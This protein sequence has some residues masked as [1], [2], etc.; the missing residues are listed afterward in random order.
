MKTIY[1]Y[2]VPERGTIDMPAGAV[3]LSV[4]T[5][6]DG[7]VVVLWA[8]LDPT[9]PTVPVAFWAEWTGAPHQAPDDA[10]FLGTIQTGDLVWHVFYKTPSKDTIIEGVIPGT[11]VRP[12]LQPNLQ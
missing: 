9:A 7:R 10:T 11:A 3:L 6:D 8:L 5:Q 4:G 1:K 12:I 2:N